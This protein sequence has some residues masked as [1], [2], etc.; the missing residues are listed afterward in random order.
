MD[1]QGNI[2]T[3]GSR[4]YRRQYYR[5]KQTNKIK[6]SDNPIFLKS[7]HFFLWSEPCDCGEKTPKRISVLTYTVYDILNTP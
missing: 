1:I 2:V 6:F 4:Q 7:H 3:I 5:E